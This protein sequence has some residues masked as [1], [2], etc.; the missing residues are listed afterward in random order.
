MSS[1]D[2]NDMKESLGFAK[3]VFLTLLCLVVFRLGVHVPCPGVNAKALVIVAEQRGSGIL[4]LLNTFSGGALEH[5]SVFALGV[6]PYISAS[7]I[8]QLLG[9]VVPTFEQW[10]KEGGSGRSKINSFTRY[11]AVLIS[12]VQG[13]MLALGLEA[14]PE[15]VV[16]PAVLYP[17]FA[18]KV[19]SALFLTCGT[20]FVM[21]LGE[22]IGEKGL[23]NG[24][25]II[26]FAGIVA[27]LPRHASQLVLLL[28]DSSSSFLV[29]AL[30]LGLVLLLLGFVVL[31]G[32]VCPL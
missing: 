11:L 3:R 6:M 1:S 14:S 9:V 5:F 31:Y 26:I 7:I 22:Q 2:V 24:V 13:F 25:S 16:G 27:Y 21:W 18:F 4:R 20:C 28:S 8:V 17:G 32:K 19:L 23:G 12:I 30:F 10:Q 15:T 29:V